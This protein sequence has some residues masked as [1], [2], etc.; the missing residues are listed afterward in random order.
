MTT[1]TTQSQSLAARFVEVRAALFAGKDHDKAN[2]KPPYE[3]I[4]K[5]GALIDRGGK[6]AIAAIV[7][8]T[9][10]HKTKFSTE[11]GKTGFTI[12]NYEW[13]TTFA[14]HHVA[15]S[16]IPLDN[17]WTSELHAKNWAK[18]VEKLK[19]VVTDDK[20]DLSE[21]ARMAMIH[22]RAM[23]MYAEIFYDETFD[24][25]PTKD[26]AIIMV[27]A[28]MQSKEKDQHIE[29]LAKF[30]KDNDRGGELKD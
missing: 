15:V 16:K 3:F 2:E 30:V 11:G 9:A 1:T 8:V 6:I 25:S 17:K 13:A 28:R 19:A 7:P 22:R 27:D 12:V 14:G 5:D 10:K 18:F 20:K 23:K 26:E 4:S 21:R 24:M 29:A